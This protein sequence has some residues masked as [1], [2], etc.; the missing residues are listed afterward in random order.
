MARLTK[1][2]IQALKSLTEVQE[3][4][5]DLKREATASLS[6]LLEEQFNVRL[7]SL[8]INL[9]FLSEAEAS[10]SEEWHLE[11][12]NG[13]DF[14]VLWTEEGIETAYEISWSQFNLIRSKVLAYLHNTGLTKLFIETT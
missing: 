11:D 6:V 4:M 1:E 2:T 9:E 5:E 14:T 12:S 8:T 13:K 10:V 3:K 7:K